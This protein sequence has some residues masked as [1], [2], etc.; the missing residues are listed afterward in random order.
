MDPLP[1][2]D[3]FLHSEGHSLTLRTSAALSKTNLAFTGIRHRTRRA[4]TFPDHPAGGKPRGST[5][6]YWTVG[7]FWRVVQPVQAVQ[8]RSSP[9][10]V[11]PIQVQLDQGLGVVVQS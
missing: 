5:S 8:C 9:I 4:Y 7:L 1:F 10:F 3:D 6:R 11:G 2:L